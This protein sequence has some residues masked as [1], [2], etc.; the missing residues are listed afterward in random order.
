MDWLVFKKVIESFLS[1]GM[2]AEITSLL[3]DVLKDDKPEDGPLQTRLLEINLMHKPTIAEAIMV[4]YGL[5]H[6]DKK[7]IAELCEK[8]GLAQ[9]VC[10]VQTENTHP[11]AI[12]VNVV[13]QL[14]I[15]YC[16]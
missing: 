8:A 3:L 11:Q 6:Y 10:R 13:L 4:K 9:R 15:A 12:I 14:T 1:R 5:S 7:R 2:V 16:L